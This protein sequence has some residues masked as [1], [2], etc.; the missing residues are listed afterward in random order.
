MK[1]PMT[2]DVTGRTMLKNVQRIA[3]IISWNMATTQNPHY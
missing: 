3:Y 2:L 1:R